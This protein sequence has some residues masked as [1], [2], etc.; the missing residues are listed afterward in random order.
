M[1]GTGIG[2][3]NGILIKEAESLELAHKSRTHCVE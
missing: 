1:V 2:A 3:E